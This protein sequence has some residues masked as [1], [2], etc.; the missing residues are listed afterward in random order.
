MTRLCALLVTAVALLAT[1]GAHLT[2]VSNQVEGTE[3][4]SLRAAPS[5]RSLKLDNGDNLAKRSL[6]TVDT[7]D[8]AGEE[9]GIP[10]ALSS[11][12][13][14][15]KERGI[16]S[17]LY[18]ALSKLMKTVKLKSFSN[19]LQIKA[20]LKAG[21]DPKDVYKELG[22]TGKELALVESQPGFKL[23]LDFG[24]AWREKG[25]RYQ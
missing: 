17:S 16:Q 10:P 8:A 14:K 19:K 21:M 15:F 2:K 6:R 11:A 5:Y 12:F 9:R 4:A 23:Y 18:Y 3:L 7:T 25:G 20:W 24:K 1:T 22:Y 13:T